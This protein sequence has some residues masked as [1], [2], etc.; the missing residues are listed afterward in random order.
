MK[1]R[2]YDPVH[3]MYDALSA[4]DITLEYVFML[5]GTERE[6]MRVLKHGFS[7]GYIECYEMLGHVK[8][9]LD[10]WELDELA[11]NKDRSDAA[12]NK[13]KIVFIAV[14]RKGGKRIKDQ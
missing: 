14:T 10:V 3:E 6:A 1:K 5:F 2:R 8:R 13:L 12:K 7:D 4:G 11:R 9:Y